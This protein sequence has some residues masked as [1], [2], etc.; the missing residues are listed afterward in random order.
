MSDTHGHWI[1]Y[2][3][4]TPEPPAARAFYEAVVGWQIAPG[5]APT[6]YDMIGNADGGFTGGVLPLS[7]DMAAAGARPGWLGYVGV[8]DIDAAVAHVRALGGGVRIP[9]MEIPGTGIF[10]MITDPDGAPL[11][12][13]QPTPPPGGG[14]STA[15]DRALPG[16][17]GWNELHAGA[18]DGALAFYTALFG[19]TSPGGMDMGP[20]G[21]YHFIDHAGD[22]VGAMMQQ[23][24]GVD[25][26]PHW[27]FY[28]RVADIDVAV[29][30]IAAQGGAVVNGPHPVPTGDWV[31]HGRDPQGGMFCLV[32]RRNG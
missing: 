20:M 28:F 7:P 12:L 8:D 18:I 23:P 30:A 26:P 32:G 13:M 16:R 14:R 6:F 9:R 27:N 10:A 29:A 11:Y 22:Q 31:L 3:L 17:C 5:A 1:W 2:E 21:T 25:A 24:A 19:W 15:F 4:W